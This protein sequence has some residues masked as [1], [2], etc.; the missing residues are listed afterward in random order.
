MQA[1]PDFEPFLADTVEA[2]DLRNRGVLHPSSTM[3]NREQYILVGKDVTDR[4]AVCAVGD[5]GSM[6][7]EHPDL[8]V[9]AHPHMYGPC[10][11]CGR[12]RF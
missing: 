5:K 1:G 12:P 2:L 7:A 11:E 6:R 8:E 10:P 4:I 3:P 9:K